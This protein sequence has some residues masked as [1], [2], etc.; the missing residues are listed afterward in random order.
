[1]SISSYSH[2]LYNELV[3]RNCVL[4][5]SFVG[6]LELHEPDK[7]EIKNSGKFSVDLLQQTSSKLAKGSGR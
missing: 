7:K 6:I 4:S 5:W 1:M 3:V 2:I